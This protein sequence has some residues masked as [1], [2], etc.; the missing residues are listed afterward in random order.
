MLDLEKKVLYYLLK[1]KFGFASFCKTLRSSTSKEKDVTDKNHFSFKILCVKVLY[2]SRMII[3]LL[4]LCSTSALFICRASIIPL[5]L[6]LN[7]C[8]L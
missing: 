2:V 3:F 1:S 7:R 4:H 8:D 6:G 5:F